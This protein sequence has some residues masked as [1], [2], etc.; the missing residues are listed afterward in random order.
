MKIIGADERLNE[1]RGV[2]LLIAGPTGVGKTSLL[3]TLPDPSRVLFL[4]GDDPDRR[5]ADRA[6][7]RGPY[8]RAQPVVCAN[9]L[10]LRG[11]LQGRRGRAGKSRTL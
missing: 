5:L 7:Y 4:D 1:P 11:A 10:L 2:K 3:R 6:R 8:R 9:Q